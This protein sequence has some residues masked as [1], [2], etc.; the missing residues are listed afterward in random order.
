MSLISGWG[1]Y[2]VVESDVR[3]PSSREAAM[4]IMRGA[5]AFVAR[6]NGRSYGDAALGCGTTLCTLG[7]DRMIGF[8]PATGVLRAEAGVL[9]SDVIGVFLPRGFFPFVVPGTCHVTLGGAIAA[10]VHG[11]NHHKEGGFGEHVLEVVLATGGTTPV[12]AS[13][14]E[15]PELFWATVGGMGL[16]GTILEASIRLRPVD[17]G[18]IRQ[19]TVVAQD[20]AAALATLDATADATYS[21]AWIDCLAKG[22][23]HGRSLVFLG[24]HACRGELDEQRSR[25]RFPALRAS[26]LSVPFDFPRF[27]LNRL[28]V[29]M[30]NEAYFRL[31]AAK[32]GAPSLVSMGSYFFPLDGISQ[33]NRIYGRRG[34]VQYQFVLPEAA[35]AATIAEVLGRVARRGD[36]SFL[37]VLK[38]LGRARG[39]LSFPMPGYTLALDFAMSPG[40]LGFLSELDR[41]V[42]AAG[43]RFYLAKDA[44]QSRTTFDAGYP[45]ADSFR[46]FRRALDGSR[47]NIRSH[48][49]DR[50]AL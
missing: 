18:W 32:A 16:T 37:A 42:V 13:R 46:R 6:G 44:R 21:V 39:A 11:K 4:S 41:I 5:S 10:D 14:D 31:G 48:L 49:S 45:E 30:F 1:R 50:L 23:N 8:D 40:L 47:N 15:N 35:A 24:E 43:G 3:T 38:K 7:L 28:T 26:R 34:F 25:D 12:R 29:A 27:G 22:R 2:P 20:L 36:A 17:T 9:L 33:W 19:I